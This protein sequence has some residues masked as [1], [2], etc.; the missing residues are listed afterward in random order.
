MINL[1]RVYN[2]GQQRSG[3]RKGK[4]SGPSA[5]RKPKGKGVHKCNWKCRRV[6]LR[7]PTTYSFR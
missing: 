7:K 6:K 2:N 5:W 1:G 4:Q 3:R